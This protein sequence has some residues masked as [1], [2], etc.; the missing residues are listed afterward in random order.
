MNVLGFGVDFHLI[1]IYARTFNAY[2]RGLKKG[3]TYITWYEKVKYFNWMYLR[4]F[5]R[6]SHITSNPMMILSCFAES[7][8][9]TNHFPSFSKIQYASLMKLDFSMLLLWFLFSSSF[10]HSLFLFVFFLFFFLLFF[11]TS[12]II[13]II[14][15]SQLRK[16]P[17]FILYNGHFLFLPHTNF[18]WITKAIYPFSKRMQWLSYIKPLL[19]TNLLYQARLYFNSP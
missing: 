15:T 3:L 14:H 6:Q 8:I 9:C 17:W 1:S 12:F 18:C 10:V 16:K 7:H 4:M 2:E 19:Q 11:L 5:H 13:I